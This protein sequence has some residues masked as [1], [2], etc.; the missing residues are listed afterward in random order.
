MVSQNIIPNSFLWRKGPTAPKT[1]MLKTHKSHSVAL[2]EMPV[3][4]Q[5]QGKRTLILG[6]SPPPK[7]PFALPGRSLRM[8]MAH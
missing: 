8:M 3:R 4:D 6:L 1:K 5:G 2:A 7:L